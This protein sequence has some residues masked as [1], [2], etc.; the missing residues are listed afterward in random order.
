MKTTDKKRVLIVVDCQNDFITGSLAIPGAVD[1]VPKIVDK[2]NAQDNDVL[3]W[4]TQDTHYANYLQTHEGQR[5]PVEHC[6]NARK[7]W[8]IH[9]D[10]EKA[11]KNFRN[12]KAGDYSEFCKNG[13]GCT[14]MICFIEKMLGWSKRWPKLDS[15][16]SFELVGFATDICVISNAMLLRSYYPDADITVDASCCAGV[17]KESHKNALSAMKMCHI[18]VINEE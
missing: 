8:D 9:E 15:N 18:D 4:F 13:F 7:G 11:A 16:L 14:Q 10:V 6:I 5:L 2:I 3:L 1:I 12:S 17:T